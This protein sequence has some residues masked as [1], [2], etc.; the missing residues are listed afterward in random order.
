MLIVTPWVRST[1]DNYR[2]RALIWKDGA[3]RN[4]SEECLPTFGELKTVRTYLP[5]SKDNQSW[6]EQVDALKKSIDD[7]GY[8]DVSLLGCGAY[9][10]AVFRHIE[11]LSFKP[12]A[13]YIGGALQL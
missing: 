10:M 7:V 4:S 9:G 3:F 6:F 2:N 11:A 13:I 1:E 5:N 12:S 8:F